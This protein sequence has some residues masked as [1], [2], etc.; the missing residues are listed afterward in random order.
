MKIILL[1]SL[2]TTVFGLSINPLKVEYHQF[3]SS[4]VGKVKDDQV[5]VSG[6]KYDSSAEE[7]NANARHFKVPADVYKRAHR[8]SQSV[9]RASPGDTGGHGTAFYVGGNLILTNQHVLSPK[10]TNTTE[11]KSFSIRL[12]DKQRGKTLKCKKIHYCSKRLDFC[13][14]E[15]KDHRKGYSLKKEIPLKLYKNNKYDSKMRTMVIG[16][17]IGFGIH[18]STGFGTKARGSIRSFLPQFIFHAPLYGGN[19]GGPIFDDQDNVIGIATMQSKVLE[20]PEAYNI[21]LPME[22]VLTVL[23]EKLKLTPE[24]LNQLND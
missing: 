23:E 16:N 4:R 14:I 15:M 18:S 13:L 1:L 2:T 21:G 19:S 3:E 20:G 12:N 10:R 11:C 6:L 9:F 7:Y 22:T 17:P 5:K 24:V 8:L